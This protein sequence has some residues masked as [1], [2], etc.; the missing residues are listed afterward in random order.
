[1]KSRASRRGVVLLLLLLLFT[2][3]PPLRAQE[4]T[5]DPVMALMARMTPEAKIGQLALVTYPGTDVGQASEIA[6]LIRTYR[7]GGVLLR[8]QNG[9]FGASG[10]GTADMIS[11]TNQLQAL[12]WDAAAAGVL[13]PSEDPSSSGA[14]PYIPLLIGLQAADAGVAPVELISGASDLPT[15]MALGATWDPDLSKA[16]GEVMGAELNA[17]GFNLY[18]GPDLD[19]LYTPKPGDPADLGT[20]VFGG[21]PFWV[22]EMGT[23]YIAGLHEGA[24]GQLAVA[25]RHLPGLGSADRPLEDEVPTVQEPLEQLKQI[26]LVP[27][28]AAAKSLPG[29][30]EDAADAFLVTHIRYRG[31]QGNNI[32]R[33]TRPISLDA[34][35]LQ[36]VTS[37]KEVEP[38]RTAG[39]VLIADN[40]GLPSVQLLY[41]PTGLTFNARRVT[42][43][44]LSAGNDLMILDRFGS[45]TNW[46]VHF[47][48][49]RDT[50]K[51]LTARYVDEP[52]FQAQVDSAV[53]RILSMKLRIMPSFSI[54]ALQKETEVLLAAS[55]SGEAV[56]TQTAL[57]GLSLVFP[58]SED[59]LPSPP[60]DGE[61]IV[62]FTQERQISVG[63]G[64]D[65]VKLLDADMIPQAIL[66]FYGPSGMGVVR[67]ASV[68]G[69]SF[70]DLIQSMDAP[71]AVAEGQAPLPDQ[72]TAVRSALRNA[73]WIIFATAGIDPDDPTSLG[74][75]RFLATQANLLDARMVVLAFGPP[76]E[77]DTTELSKLAEYYA[78]Y[79][80]GSAF[81]ETGVRALFQDVLAPGASPVDIPA[82]NY[83]LSEQM[84]PNPDQTISLAIVDEAG[85]ELTTTAKSDIHV[86]DVLYLETGVIVDGNGHVVPD[87]TPVQ[88]N[89]SY[90]Q[91]G[92][93]NSVVGETADGIANASISL[94]RVGQL[95]VTAQSEPAVSSTRLE[96]TIRDDGVTITEIEP[97]E[98]PT[99]TPSPTLTPAPLPTATPNPVP[100]KLGQLPDHPL[101]PQPSRGALIRWALAASFGIFV[102]AY[103]WSRERSQS[104]DLATMVA[105]SSMIGSLCGYIVLMAA[106][107]WWLPFV[108]F[109]L[110][111][112]EYLVAVAVAAAGLLTFSVAS[113]VPTHEEAAAWPLSIGYTEPT[114]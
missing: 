95:D 72:V 46:S 102:V 87:G 76:Y 98:V 73:G 32:R 107:R 58:L 56:A 82:L 69:F 38:W 57:E 12:A 5:N 105:L 59:L 88:F 114:A 89:L 74:L 31:F 30:A 113:A 50:L 52:T 64:L 47:A 49:V 92:S 104:A 91:E 55:G 106:A 37:L 71:A 14:S 97:T 19:V 28:F 101:L 1:M 4:A 108:R 75:K 9:N 90:P 94:D 2:V 61:S 22:G 11:I 51:F 48:N 35:A 84:M 40:L 60:Q 70:K 112:R 78:L 77:L 81:V 13:P 25:P 54:D 29:T 109:A 43:D 45:E 36:L 10:M 83:T 7:I 96:L 68:R 27:F 33:T 24:G 6:E 65:P 99:V 15:S 62:V 3:V 80:P 39:G 16:A 79:S 20:Q 111:G 66:R 67:T 85:N 41:D 18:L 26:E 44:A 63:D 34:P 8:P 23:A 21:D 100:A 93:R 86:G 110:V 103:L 42:Q 17:L 53:Y